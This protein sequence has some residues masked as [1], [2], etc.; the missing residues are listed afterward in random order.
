MQVHVHGAPQT[1]GVQTQVH[2][3]GDPAAY[4]GAGCGATKLEDFI[5]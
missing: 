5:V 3:G 4:V 1:S 2:D